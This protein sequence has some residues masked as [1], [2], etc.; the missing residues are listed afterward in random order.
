MRRIKNS[1]GEDKKKGTG[2]IAADAKKLR[3]YGEQTLIIKKAR[4][5]PT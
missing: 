3:K 2:Y 1:A 4:S 5:T